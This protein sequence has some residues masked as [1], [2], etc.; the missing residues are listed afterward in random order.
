MAEFYSARGWEIPPLPW[1]N[2]SPPFSDVDDTGRCNI[3]FRIHGR[4][5]RECHVVLT[6][7]RGH[8]NLDDERSPRCQRPEEL[9]YRSVASRGLSWRKQ[10]ARLRWFG[11]CERQTDSW[12]KLDREWNDLLE[13]IQVDYRCQSRTSS[14]TVEASF[15]R[16]LW[17]FE[18]RRAQQYVSAGK[19]QRW[20]VA[21]ILVG[22]SYEGSTDT[23]KRQSVTPTLEA[24]R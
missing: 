22:H 20:R 15:G 18:R 19:Q 9:T 14:A 16:I 23:L 21:A 3:L 6:C 5:Q 12:M 7:C 17:N 4:V 1:T 11:A 10:V 8:L 2:L 13:G 24:A